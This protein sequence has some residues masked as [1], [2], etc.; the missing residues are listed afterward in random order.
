MIECRIEIAI[1]M[2]SIEDF[3]PFLPTFKHLIYRLPLTIVNE[4]SKTRSQL[5]TRNRQPEGKMIIY[6][7]EIFIAPFRAGGGRAW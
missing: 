3:F 4:S 2:R 5:G 7:R 1:S 6:C